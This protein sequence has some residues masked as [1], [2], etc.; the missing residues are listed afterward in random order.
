MVE[1]GR[2]TLAAPP[3]I[4]C[5]DDVQHL[6]IIAPFLTVIDQP[7]ETNGSVAAQ[8]LLER[9]VG[10]A[11]EKSRRIAFQGVLTVRRSCGVATP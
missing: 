10:R 7:A 4:P 11:G 8:L 6:A 2:M 1:F 5:L 3:T 9:I